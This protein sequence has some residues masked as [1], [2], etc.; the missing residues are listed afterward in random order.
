MSIIL[1]NFG[2][3]AISDCP[4]MLFV[5][6][7]RLKIK[8]IVLYCIVLYI[9]KS[10]I[11]IGKSYTDI[12][13]SSYIPTSVNHLND[14]SEIQIIDIGNSIY[15]CMYLYFKMIFQYR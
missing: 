7:N 15:R 8:L 1:A 14:L 5:D 10:T 13:K 11:D 6:W 4:F 2:K 9:G 3:Y 12:G